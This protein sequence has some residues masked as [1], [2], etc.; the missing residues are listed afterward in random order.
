MS[1][2]DDN[3]QLNKLKTLTGINNLPKNI[4]VATMTIICVFDCYF[5]INNIGEY[6]E[7]TKDGIIRTK[8]TKR[9]KKEIE[10]LEYETETEEIEDITK[11]RRYEEPIKKS[12]KKKKELNFYNQTELKVRC[13]CDDDTVRKERKNR[14]K[15]ISVKIFRNGTAHFTG[16][17]TIKGLH[18]VIKIL[19]KYLRETKAIKNVDKNNNTILK[20]IKFSSNPDALYVDKIVSTYI[21]LINTNFTVDFKIDRVKLKKLMDRLK[22]PCKY[23]PVKYSGVNISYDYEGIKKVSI[24]IFRSGSIVITG[25]R[26]CNQIKKAYN[27]ICSILK[28]HYREIIEVSSKQLTIENDELDELLEGKSEIIK[29]QILTLFQNK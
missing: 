2:S 12:K 17:A 27:F 23:N 11:I 15:I 18:E 9:I 14:D 29:K 7:L 22:I 5:Y 4:S 6:V 10:D 3:E 21:S 26:S 1:D 19:T 20:E 16:C 8:Y 25:G 24:L 13:M 28:K